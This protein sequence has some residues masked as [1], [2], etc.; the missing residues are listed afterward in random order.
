VDGAGNI[1]VTNR[2]SAM[3]LRSTAAPPAPRSAP[4][5]YEGGGNATIMS[6]PLNVS[7]DPSGNL[8][9]ANYTGS[10]IVELVGIGAPTYM[11]LSVAA[12]VDKLGSKP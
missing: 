2:T 4:C 11:P 10:R 8:W 6:D 1:F 5:N 3:T 9:V 12:S 7:M